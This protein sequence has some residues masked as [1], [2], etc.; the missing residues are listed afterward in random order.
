[1]RKL[2]EKEI[3]EKIETIR[4]AARVSAVW[5][6]VYNTFCVPVRLEV[7]SGELAR[8]DSGAWIGFLYSHKMINKL[9]LGLSI[10]GKEGFAVQ[11]LE[12]KVAIDSKLV[13]VASIWD[14][15]PAHRRALYL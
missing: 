14:E 12:G 13:S 15:L 7:P 6:K 8:D 5:N 11:G 1:V 10:T 2:S 4:D 9:T 3:A